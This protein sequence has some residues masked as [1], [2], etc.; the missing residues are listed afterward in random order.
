M[1]VDAN[2]LIYERLREELQ[3]KGLDLRAAVKVGY[4][5]ALLARSW[6]AT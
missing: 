4:Q 5:K 1:A 3:R 6:T 2:V